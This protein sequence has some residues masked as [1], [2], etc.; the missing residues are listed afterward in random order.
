MDSEEIAYLLEDDIN[1]FFRNEFGIS[2]EWATRQVIA[3]FVVAIL[4]KYTK[5]KNN[6]SWED[7]GGTNDG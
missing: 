1:T 3:R 6:E 4:D 5:L 7:S 2:F